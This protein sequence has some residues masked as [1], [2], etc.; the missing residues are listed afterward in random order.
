VP[1]RTLY[2]VSLVV[3]I[4]VFNNGCS[5]RLINLKP[6]EKAQLKAQEEISV[7]H[8][9]PPSFFL[10]TPSNASIHWIILV[11][12]ALTLGILDLS[13]VGTNVAA[14]GLVMQG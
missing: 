14:V 5:P 3:V 12:G 4:F 10:Y 1:N 6:E 13:P 11:G 8:Q 2:W 7:F 9:T